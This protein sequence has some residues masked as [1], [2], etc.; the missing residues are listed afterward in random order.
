MGWLAVEVKRGESV[1]HVQTAHDC[2]KNEHFLDLLLKIDHTLEIAPVEKVWF[3]IFYFLPC[4]LFSFSCIYR[5]TL[6]TPNFCL[7]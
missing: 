6:E 1:I 5:A 7:E 2:D 4:E 3:L